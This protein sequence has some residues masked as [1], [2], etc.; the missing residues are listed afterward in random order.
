MAQENIFYIKD[1]D[2]APTLD[3]CVSNLKHNKDCFLNSLN[4]YISDRL[5]L[6]FDSLNNPIEGKVKAYLL[7]NKT[8]ELKIK[9]IRS[10]NKKLQKILFR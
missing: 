6:S 10:K 9:T 1:V 4:S 3:F 8:G 5:I 2:K 7:F